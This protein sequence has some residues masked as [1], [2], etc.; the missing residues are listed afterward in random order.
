M[1]EPSIRLGRLRP[2]QRYQWRYCGMV[3]SAASW[4]KVAR[5]LIRALRVAGDDVEVCE[6]EADRFDPSIEL[7]DLDDLV[8]GHASGARWQFTFD[9]PDLYESMFSRGPRIGLLVSE[10]DALPALWV[11]RAASE[12]D[13]VVFPSTYCA[14]VAISSGLSRERVSVVPH[15]ATQILFDIGPIPETRVFRVLFVGTAAFRK[16]LDIL[17]RAFEVAFRGE[18]S[19]LILKLSDYP[20]AEERPYLLQTW[21]ADVE[22]LRRD[23]YAISVITDFLSEQE[24]AQLYGSAHVI[25][26]PSRG[27]GFC[28]PLLEA[29]AAARPVIATDHGG[30][31]DFMNGLNAIPIPPRREIPARPHLPNGDLW[32]AHSR[33]VEPDWREVAAALRTLY[34]DRD[35]AVRL[36]AAGRSSASRLTW[37]AAAAGMRRVAGS[38]APSLVPTEL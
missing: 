5:E 25:C 8:V 31:R 22:A 36:G 34:R 35:L 37:S 20:D 2:P 1:T 12:L 14:E 21:R 29:M 26:Q 33:L 16:G 10:V 13:H 23:G 17:L 15:G 32:P 30:P 4:A 18:A 3:R 11:R 6:I 9:S 24:L 27:E 28:M 7:E 38:L 19:E